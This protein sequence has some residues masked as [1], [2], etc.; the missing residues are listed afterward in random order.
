MPVAEAAGQAS[1]VGHTT[2]TEKCQQ[3]LVVVLPLIITAYVV[4]KSY[5]LFTRSPSFVLRCHW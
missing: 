3:L 2:W 4:P 1:Q 5:M